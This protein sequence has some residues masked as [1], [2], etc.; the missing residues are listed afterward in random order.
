MLV[1]QQVRTVNMGAYTE[2]TSCF[3]SALATDRVYVLA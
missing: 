3:G 1:I 2:A